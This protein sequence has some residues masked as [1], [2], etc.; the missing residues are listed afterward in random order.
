MEPSTEFKTLLELVC[1]PDQA[2]P[3]FQE[4]EAR[5]PWVQDM[6]DCPQPIVRHG[7]GEVWVHTRMVLEALR[8]AAEWQGLPR[9][10]REI[11]LLAAL[12]HDVGKPDRFFGQR[13]GARAGGHPVRGEILARRILWEMEAPLEVRETV[14]QLTRFHQEPFR[15]LE[16][17][18]PDRMIRELSW[19]VRPDLLW[20]L[21]AANARGR[22]APNRDELLAAVDLFRGA[23]EEAGCFDGPYPFPSD[24]SRME[25]LRSPQRNPLYPAHD[26]PRCEMVVLCGLPGSGKTHWAWENLGDM[27]VEGY[28]RVRRRLKLSYGSN[29]G[30]VRQEGR[31]RMRVRLRAGESF[32]F[33]SNALTRT[34][35]SQLVNL[36]MDYGA[37]V[38]ILHVEATPEVRDRWNAD[39]EEAV[40]LEAFLPVLDRWEFPAAVEAH[41]VEAVV[42]RDPEAWRP[43]ALP[44]RPWGGTRA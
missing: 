24:Q 27:P 18:R 13:G 42:H 22:I 11:L 38:R 14:A 29:E 16:S 21:A 6:A 20:L 36:A 1:P 10:Q 44:I 7:E 30:R 8:E 28:D 41:R 35:R 15:L 37:R 40:P 4:L 33:E 23:A 2:L 39:R 31:E 25:W 3:D 9:G 5:Y 32:V 12:L 19:C 17:D 34:L 26:D 43:Q